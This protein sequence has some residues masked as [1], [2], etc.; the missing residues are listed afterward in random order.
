MELRD[1]QINAIEKLGVELAKGKKRIVLHS[2]TGCL[3]GDTIVECNRAG[4]SFKIKIK[5]LVHRFNGGRI[6]SGKAKHYNPVQGN[7]CR[8][9]SEIPTDI[10][11]MDKDGFI[12]LHRLSA[13]IDSGIK[14]T[15]TVT[16]ESGER[17]RATLD[18]KFLTNNGWKRLSELTLEDYLFVEGSPKETIKK[19][20]P[21]YRITSRTIVSKIICIE[22]YGPEHTYDLCLNDEPHNFMANR[23]CVHNSGKTELGMEIIMR[24]SALNKRTIFVCNRIQ[25]VHQ[26]SNR[27]TKSGIWHG[28]IQGQNTSNLHD[29]VNVCSIQTLARRGYPEADIII[30]D[31][32]HGTAGSKAYQGLMRHFKD[33]VIIG[34]TATPYATGMAKQYDWGTLWEGIVSA[35]SIPSLISK[36]YL[37]DCEIYAPSTPDLSKVRIVAGDYDEKQLGDAVDKPELIG[38]IVL[39]WKRL[40]NNKPTVVFA[41]NILHSQH[42]TSQFKAIGVSAEHIDC[43]T[44]DEDRKGILARVANGDTLVISNVGILTEGWD[45]PQCEVLVLARPTKSL[46]RYIQMAGRVLRPSN[47]KTIATILDHS[48]TCMKLGFP[49]EEFPLELCNGTKKSA[50]SKKKI[51]EEK[52]EKLPMQCKKCFAVLTPSMK[53]CPKCGNELP[54][55]KQ[56]FKNASGTL[57]NVKKGGMLSN[58]SAPERLRIFAE[59]KGYA[60]QKGYKSG[61]A[62]HKVR[63]LYGIAPKENPQ[64]L[65]PSAATLSLIK[66]ITIKNSYR[67]KSKSW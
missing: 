2:P 19:K 55:R 24:A 41:T 11:S 23:I 47:G 31:E 18:H 48:G 57:V 63:E 43:Y 58:S 59:L 4:K 7:G 28:V 61:W 37:V 39:H 20:K 33:K 9:D 42:I 50:E 53:V 45:F 54:K 26:T 62:W 22:Y 10:R 38:D 25:L 52:K 66:Y 5:D 3:A 17:V 29:L 12:R 64:P 14:D 46:I 49:T 27:L 40:A 13:A 16:T 36:G 32:S 35:A 6:I 30:I 56:E 15:Y 34:L 21:W 51:E 1:Y 8:W 44:S 60:A 65:A 67:Q